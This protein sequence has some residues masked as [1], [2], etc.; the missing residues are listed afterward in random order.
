MVFEQVPDHIERGSETVSG[1]AEWTG[2]LAGKAV[3]LLHVD[4]V[5]VVPGKGEIVE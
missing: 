1:L 4:L 2:R 5:R 3:Q